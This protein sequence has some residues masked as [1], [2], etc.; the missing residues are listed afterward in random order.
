[1]NAITRESP[2][3]LEQIFQREWLIRYVPRSINVRIPHLETGRQEFA[4]TVGRD[5]QALLDALYNWSDLLVD[6]PI[7][8]VEVLRQ[9]ALRQFYFDDKRDSLANICRRHSAVSNFH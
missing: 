5:I 7:P 9:V 6:K 3:W 2:S 8:A 4:E 1:M